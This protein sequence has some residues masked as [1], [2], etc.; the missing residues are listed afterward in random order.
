ME[1]KS[2]EFS[3]PIKGSQIS[4]ILSPRKY[5]SK[6]KI[7]EDPE[8]PSWNRNTATYDETAKLISEHPEI[9][10]LFFPEEIDNYPE[11]RYLADGLVYKARISNVLRSYQELVGHIKPNLKSSELIIDI[12]VG[13]GTMG[14]FLLFNS[15]PTAKIIATDS[16]ISSMLGVINYAKAGFD[17]LVI[18]KGLT[19]KP[20]EFGKHR[21]IY[22]PW[23]FT[24]PPPGWL[25]GL[26]DIVICDH[27]IVYTSDQEQFEKN[28]QHAL[29][30]FKP[31]KK[32][33]GMLVV[34]QLN[35]N[36]PR[37][38]LQRV[39][40]MEVQK[41]HRR[42]DPKKGK[43]AQMLREMQ[44]ASQV[45]SEFQKHQ[46]SVDEVTNSIEDIGEL[47]TVELSDG[48]VLGHLITPN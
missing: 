33:G 43:G 41:I 19:S 39:M 16:G 15:N 32:T 40:G 36:A 22:T 25:K 17:T 31:E 48:I 42:Y 12:G 4:R 24:K 29:D 6:L 18:P 46:L 44:L 13:T 28:L 37:D 26:A 14:M 10:P 27:S 38:L 7:V 21:M 20:S 30:M 11:D 35:H 8:L 45:K 9:E 23:N 34:T 3:K 2:Q 5:K 47:K 1:K